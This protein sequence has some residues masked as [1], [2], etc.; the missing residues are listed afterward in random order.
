MVTF[1]VPKFWIVDGVLLTM[2]N[3]AWILIVDLQMDV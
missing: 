1:D 2:G 3:G